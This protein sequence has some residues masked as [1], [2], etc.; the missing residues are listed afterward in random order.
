MSTDIVDSEAIEKSDELGI[1][2]FRLRKGSSVLVLAVRVDRK[3]LNEEHEK[4]SKEEGGEFR[5][6]ESAFDLCEMM[7]SL[8]G[9]L[10]K[11]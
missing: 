6:F 11:E 8:R 5:Y 7:P 1:V 2:K 10:K 3:L 9:L 4:R